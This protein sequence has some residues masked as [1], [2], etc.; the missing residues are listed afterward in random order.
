[1]FNINKPPLYSLNTV[2]TNIK[3]TIKFEQ[4]LTVYNDLVEYK[5]VQNFGLS[6]I[7]ISVSLNTISILLLSI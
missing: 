6:A 3:V 2:S 4:G 1:M 7:T 5:Y